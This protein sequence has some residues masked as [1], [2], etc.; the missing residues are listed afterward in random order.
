MVRECECVKVSAWVAL[1]GFVRVTVDGPIP[2]T[3][4]TATPLYNRSTLQ[5]HRTSSLVVAGLHVN[6]HDETIPLCG[7]FS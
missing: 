5:D 7:D 3:V 6:R 1:G 4:V 2:L